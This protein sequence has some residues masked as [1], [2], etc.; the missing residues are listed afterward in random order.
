MKVLLNSN[1]PMVF[2]QLNVEF[3]TKFRAPA[4]EAMVMPSPSWPSTPP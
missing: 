3:D 1:S 2:V 4:A